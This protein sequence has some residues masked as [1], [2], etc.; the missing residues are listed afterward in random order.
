MIPAPPAKIAVLGTGLL[1]GSLLAALRKKSP[2]LHLCAWARRTDSIQEITRL[3]LADTASTDLD[4]V[5]QGA[6]LVIL[7][8]PVEHMAGLAKQLNPAKLAPHCVVTDVGSVKAPVVTAVEDVLAAKKIAFVGSHPMAG[9]EKSGLAGARADL[10]EGMTCIITPTLFT[11]EIA[12]Q[13]V[14]WLWTQAGCHLL[15]MS[16]EEHDRK[17]ASISHMPHLAAVAVALSALQQ[18]ASTAHCMGNGFRDTT[19]IASGNPELWTG[20]ISQNREPVLAALEELQ[21]VLG[22][23]TQAIEQCDDKALHAILNQAKSLRDQAIPG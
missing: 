2:A 14:R 18:D 11:E 15:E 17:I 19:R 12:L 21:T 23:L 10:F 20:I 5:T 22:R 13:Q 7:C 8:T 16:P 9:S 6:E 3:K 4:V 1:G